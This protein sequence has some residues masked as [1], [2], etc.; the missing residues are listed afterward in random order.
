M[1]E[2]EHVCENCGHVDMAELRKSNPVVWDGRR[3][4]PKCNV[5][6]FKPRYS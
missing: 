4:C 5:N 6:L 1:V 2:C 3:V